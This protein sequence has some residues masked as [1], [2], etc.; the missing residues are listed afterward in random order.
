M[1]FSGMSIKT[2]KNI[3]FVVRIYRETEKVFRFNVEVS[4]FEMQF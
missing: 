4:F 2:Y 1:R 3:I